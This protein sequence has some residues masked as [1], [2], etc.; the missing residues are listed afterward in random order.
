MREVQRGDG[1][2]ATKGERAAAA[3]LGD[4]AYVTA[5]CRGITQRV[6]NG[7]F[8]SQCHAQRPHA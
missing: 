8:S 5:V 7:L 4:R 3:V 1:A 6:G 2:Q